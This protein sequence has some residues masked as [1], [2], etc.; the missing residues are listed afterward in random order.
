[1]LVGTELFFEDNAYNFQ[2]VLKK[3][4]AAY[5]IPNKLYVDY[6]EDKTNPKKAGGLAGDGIA[7]KNFGIVVKACTTY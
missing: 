7:G 2:K 4:V 3:A 1:M 6:A 5:G